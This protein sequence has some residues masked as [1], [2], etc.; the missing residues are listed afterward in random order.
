MTLFDEA[1]SPRRYQAIVIGSG[2]TGGWAAKELC[3]AGLATL[4]LERGRH[5]EHGDYPTAS[6]DPWDVTDDAEGIFKIGEGHVAALGD[7][8]YTPEESAHYHVQQRTGWSATRT[9][10][11]HYVDDLK[12]PYK[13]APGKGFD[14]IRGYQTGGRS[15]IWGR[16]SYRWAPIDFEMNARQGIAVDWPIR[17]RDLEPYYAKVEDYIGVSGAAEGRPDRLPDGVFSPPM[18][19]M[20]PEVVFRD[21]LAREY[22]DGRFA[23]IGRVA[24]LTGRDRPG[25]QLCQFRNRCERGCPYGGYFSSNASTLPAADRTGK[26]TLRPHSIVKAIDYDDTTGR[27]TGVVIVDELTKEE[28]RFEADVFFLNASAMA[29]AAILMQSGDWANGSGQLGRNIMDHHYQLGANA[30]AEGM[31][32]SYYRGR[33]P[34]GIYVPQFANRPG[35]TAF[36]DFLRGFGYQGGAYR[37]G[38]G[39]GVAE[40]DYGADFKERMMRPGKW[41]FGIFGFGEMLPDPDNYVT[42][43]AERDEWGLPKLVFHTE[44]KANERAMRPAI[45]SAAAEM[46]ERAGFTNV[47]EQENYDYH[48]GLGIHEMGTARMGHDPRTSVLDAHNRVHAAHNVYCTDG[49]AMTSSGTVNPSLTYMALTVRAVE[50]YVGTLT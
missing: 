8:A 26:L 17:Y 32:D 31:E 45:K 25:R 34:N 9:T 5:V 2:I 20:A 10:A 48:V 42:L 18:D 40:L 13:V 50:H 12:H 39:R 11:R 28:H 1:T 38:F 19:L 44:L 37:E 27:A 41:R 7:H 22:D 15:L 33:R 24:H 47:V 3:E 16:Q 30:E 21:A 4:V 29:S 35:G 46:L 43:G 36:P 6:L 23:T 49:A 14:W